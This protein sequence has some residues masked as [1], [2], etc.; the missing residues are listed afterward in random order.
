MFASRRSVF[1]LGWGGRGCPPGHVAR[2]LLRPEDDM[3]KMLTCIIGIAISILLLTPDTAS[4]RAGGGV[5]GAAIG[6]WRGGAVWRGKAIG[7]RSRG[8]GWSGASVGW[9]DP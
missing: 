7:A 9:Y 2:R 6:G 8:I 1:R 4:A 3:L 5:R